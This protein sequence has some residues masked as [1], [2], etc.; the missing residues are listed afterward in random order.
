MLLLHQLL[1]ASEPKLLIVDNIGARTNNSVPLTGTGLRQDPLVGNPY[2][3]TLPLVDFAGN[4]ATMG[5]DYSSTWITPNSSYMNG[6]DMVF[7]FTVTEAGHLSGTMT[8]VDSYLGLFILE[9]CPDPVL[10]AVVLGSAT[11]SGTSITLNDLLLEPGT[12]FA[13]VSSWP[14]PQSIAFTINLSF[15]PSPTTTLSWYNLQWPP[16]ANILANQNVTVYA[17]CYE[18]GVTEAEGPGTGIECWIGYSSDPNATPANYTYWVPATY[19]FT[20]DPNNNDEYMASL[21]A[22]RIWHQA[23]ITMPAASVVSGLAVLFLLIHLMVVAHG[24][25][26]NY[27]SPAC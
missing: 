25:G 15:V 10:P 8:T 3:I 9:D 1:P 12:Y 16:T 11:S 17:Q 21:G 13:I 18:S 20:A 5:D 14:A 7:E 6:D 2:P 26:I 27:V 4:T 23:P 19:N 22:A 24:I